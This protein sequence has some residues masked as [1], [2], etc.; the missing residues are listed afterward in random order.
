MSGFRAIL[1]RQK[2]RAKRSGG[3]GN[4]LWIKDGDI[5][6]FHFLMDPENP[7][8]PYITDYMAHALPPVGDQKWGTLAY[9]PQRSGHQTNGYECPYCMNSGEYPL[10][11][12]LIQILYVHEIL[13]P[14]KLKDTDD[15]KKIEYRDRDYYLYEVGGP[16]VWDTT[17]VYRMSMCPSS[18]M[19]EVFYQ[20][21]GDMR[22]KEI[23]LVVKG[24]QLE[25]SYIL[26]VQHESEALPDDVFEQLSD[27]PSVYEI[28]AKSIEGAEMV[29]EETEAKEEKPLFR[30]PRATN[31]KSSSA[32]PKKRFDFLKDP[33]F[34][35]DPFEE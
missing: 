33:D 20:L 21:D 16:M 9:C 27:Q 4:N 11:E 22:A 12:R 18:Q 2:E 3:S 13:R 17:G 30:K 1:S 7:N 19:E 29:E 24:K 10:K 28:L 31:G 26:R 15:A 6:R 25:L 35:E 8:D 32:E 34:D 14:S 5:V 23:E